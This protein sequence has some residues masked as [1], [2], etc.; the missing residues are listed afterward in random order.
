MDEAAHPER[1]RQDRNRIDLRLVEDVH[2]WVQ[3]IEQERRVDVA[4]MVR[5][6]DGGAI[7]RERLG[8][9]HTIA[10]ATERQPEADADVPQFVQVGLPPEEKREQH[11]DRSNDQH[12]KRNRDVGDDGSDGGDDHQGR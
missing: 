8:R 6:V 12:V 4:L 10:D 1:A 5:A 2:A 3:H 7:E 9:R 11:A